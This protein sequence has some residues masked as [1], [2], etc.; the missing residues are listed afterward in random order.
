VLN[1]APTTR[2]TRDASAGY[3]VLKAALNDVAMGSKKKVVLI[4]HSQGGIIAS[5]WVDQLLADFSRE[6]LGALEVYTFAR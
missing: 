1:V 6:V 3:E 4:A 5:A 2:P